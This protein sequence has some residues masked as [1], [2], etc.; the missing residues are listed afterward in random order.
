M[1]L[2]KRVTSKCMP[3]AQNSGLCKQTTVRQFLVFQHQYGICDHQ[4]P[5]SEGKKDKKSLGTKT[6]HSPTD[7]SLIVAIWMGV[8]W[9]FTI[10]S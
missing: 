6:P 1:H 8:S 4:D 2:S 10:Q 5:S 7:G 3:S 9:T